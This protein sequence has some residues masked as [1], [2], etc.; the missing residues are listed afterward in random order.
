MSAAVSPPVGSVAATVPPAARKKSANSALHAVAGSTAG[1][2]SK[3]VLQPMDLVKTRMQVGLHPGFGA[4]LRGVWQEGGVLGFARGLAPNLVG[5]GAAWG[6]YFWTYNSAK[7]HIRKVKGVEDPRAELGAAYNFGSAALAGTLTVLV[8]NPI[9]MVKTRLQIATGY[10]GMFDAFRRIVR[11]EGPLAL[12][13]GL[14]PALSLVSN[15]ALQFA[16][17]ERLRGFVRARM[18]GEENLRAP[19]FF[20]MGAAAKMASAT[21]TYPMQVVRSRLYQQRGSLSALEIARGVL[22]SHGWRG[23]YSGLVPQLCKSAPSSALTF[24]GY[25]TA[26]RLLGPVFGEK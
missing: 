14:G 22:A 19:H 16:V 10:S 24:L 6:V 15:G 26:V 23:F 2:F 13:R 3:T 5:S 8:T 1:V 7:A 21:A 12:Y 9:W 18:G 11:E 25:E 17:Y 20:A 4:A